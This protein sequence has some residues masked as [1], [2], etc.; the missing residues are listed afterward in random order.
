MAHKHGTVVLEWADGEYPFRLS[1]AE[2]GELEDKRDKGVWTLLKSL[3]DASCHTKDVVEVVRLGLIGGGM[4]PVE[5]MRKVRFYCEERPIEESRIIA[6]GI[7][8]A[9]M[10][11]L[12]GDKGEEASSDTG[13]AEPA[14]TTDST[15]PASSEAPQPSE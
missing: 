2:M 3:R 9:S 12:P 15:S 6:F 11:R 4:S 7:L 1:L 10:S 5:A 13:E 14:G 8:G